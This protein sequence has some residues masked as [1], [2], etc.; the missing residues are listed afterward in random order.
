MEGHILGL[1]N[2]ATQ[3]NLNKFEVSNLK[4]P[5]PP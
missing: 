5:L 4:I 1:T 3:D 2:N